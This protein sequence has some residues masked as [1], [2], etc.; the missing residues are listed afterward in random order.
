MAQ[1]VLSVRMDDETKRAFADF[2]DQIGM[3]VSTAINMFARQAIRE[4][5]LPFTPS[6]DV[7]DALSGP[8]SPDESPVA[9]DRF[10][11]AEAVKKAASSFAAIDK[12]ILFGSHARGGAR[13]DSDIDLRIIRAESGVLSYANIAAFSEAVR[14]MTGRRVD[15]ISARIIEDEM[16]AASI[17]REGVVI[18]E[19]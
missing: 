16:L 9:L 11:I 12:V 1:A 17:E 18:Y 3:S 10:A 5:R 4:R 13:L 14:A 19:R 6:L 8:V 7:S 2:C 15:V